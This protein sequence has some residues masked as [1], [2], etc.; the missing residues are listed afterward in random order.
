VIGADVVDVFPTMV[1]TTNLYDEIGWLPAFSGTTQLTVTCAV[2]VRATV[3]LRGTDGAFG[4]MVVDV[5]LDVVVVV[6][7]VVGNVV[8]DVVVD[9]VVVDVVVDVVAGSVVEVL[10]LLTC[11]PAGPALSNVNNESAP[12]TVLRATLLVDRRLDVRGIGG[13]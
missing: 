10:E 4:A 7:V 1:S 8:V 5:V 9:V 11:A 6:D 2:P 3:R 12:N 13:V